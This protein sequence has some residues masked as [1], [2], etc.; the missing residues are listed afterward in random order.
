MEEKRNKAGGRRE[1]A[2]RPKRD[3]AKLLITFRIDADLATLVKSTENKS[4][5][6]NDCIR[7]AIGDV[8][9]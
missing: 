6:I 4:H 5:F 9:K 7:V 1:G 2:G 8:V 3:D